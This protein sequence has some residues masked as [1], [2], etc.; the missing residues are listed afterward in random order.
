MSAQTKL[1]KVH[2]EIMKQSGESALIA[3]VHRIRKELGL[4]DVPNHLDDLEGLKSKAPQL[5]VRLIEAEHALRLAFTMLK[6]DPSTLTQGQDSPTKQL[7]T[8]WIEQV[9]WAN[10]HADKISRANKQ[11]RQELPRVAKAAL[12]LCYLQFV[13]AGDQLVGWKRLSDRAKKTLGQ[14]RV[15]RAERGLLTRTRVEPLLNA[16]RANE[17]RHTADEVCALYEIQP[18]VSSME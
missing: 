1:K 13:E 11:R 17:H 9:I 2:L 12:Y 6:L 8:Y 18:F 16:F 14:N 15:S 5:L 10:T 4:P 3:D 7:A